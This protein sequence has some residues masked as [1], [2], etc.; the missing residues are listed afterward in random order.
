LSQLILSTTTTTTTT[1]NN[2]NNNNNNSS[3]KSVSKMTISH[4]KTGAGTTPKTPCILSTPQ[5]DN[6]QNNTDTMN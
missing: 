5:A 6:A 2:N 3:N 4:Y 1:N